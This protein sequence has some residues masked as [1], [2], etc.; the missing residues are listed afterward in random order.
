MPPLYPSNLWINIDSL[1]LVFD[2]SKIKAFLANIK[3]FLPPQTPHG[4]GQR[5]LTGWPSSA[6]CESSRLALNLLPLAAG[7]RG[8][9]FTAP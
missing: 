9:A 5:P 2:I 7:P 8:Q 4:L 3:K 1:D 6:P